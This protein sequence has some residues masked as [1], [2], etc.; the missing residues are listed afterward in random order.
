MNQSVRLAL[1]GAVFMLSGFMAVFAV[2]APALAADMPP[3]SDA[4]KEK[5]RLIVKE[6]IREYAASLNEKQG[7]GAANDIVRDIRQANTNFMRT[8]GPAHFKPFLDSQHPRA[9]VITCSDSRV[10]THALDA[11]PDGDLFM[12]RNIGNQIVTAE[13]SVEYGVH[14]L[15]TPLLLIIGHSACGAIKAAASDYA[16]ESGPIRR[17]LDTIQIPKGDPGLNSIKLNVNNQVRQAMS[18]FENEV[19]SGHLTV[20]GAVYDFRNDMQQGQ[21]RLN[22]INVNGETDAAKIAAMEMMK[23]TPAHKP[24]RVMRR[25]IAKKAPPAEAE[26]EENPPPA[27]EHAKPAKHAPSH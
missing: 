22:I 18:K 13:G 27:S 21:G 23:E 17:E 11:S 7:H 6:V 25:P 24:M 10:H 3:M 26:S 20:M 8:H 5:I 4:E 1:L 9:T 16:K 12:I 14:H 15:H 19:I 2:V